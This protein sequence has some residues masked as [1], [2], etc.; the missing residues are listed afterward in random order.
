MTL[1]YQ[2][3][4]AGEESC[5]EPWVLWLYTWEQIL[6][7]QGLSSSWVGRVPCLSCEAH[8]TGSELPSS[9]GMQPP[10]LSS[11]LMSSSFK[12]SQSSLFAL[13][14]YG[15][16]LQVEEMPGFCLFMHR[17]GMPEA[18]RWDTRVSNFTGTFHWSQM[19]FLLLLHSSPE[20]MLTC[21]WAY[22]CSVEGC[23]S[24]KEL[25]SL[26]YM[27]AIIG[28]LQ[29]AFSVLSLSFHLL[30]GRVA[31]IFVGFTR[32]ITSIPS[33]HSQSVSVMESA[34]LNEVAIKPR[35]Y[36]FF[37]NPKVQIFQ[38]QKNAWGKFFFFFLLN[39]I[40]FSWFFPFS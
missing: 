15:A 31:T 22:S 23:L 27:A 35:R 16:A 9:R 3:M 14:V 8:S 37:S 2:I 13:R 19:P 20:F 30:D 12:P 17:Q 5:G 26:F 34:K 29:F 24:S 18:M 4:I 10:W 39:F 11:P 33:L 36:R 38:E 7:W 1:S 21:N 6:H 28:A 25:L 40:E 32:F